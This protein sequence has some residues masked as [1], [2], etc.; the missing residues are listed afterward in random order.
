[1]AQL[2]TGTSHLEWPR[3][4]LQDLRF[5]S[6][7]LVRSPGF[8]LVAATVLALGIGAN[9]AIFCFVRAVVIAPLP[10]ANPDRLVAIWEANLAEGKDHERV[11]PPNFVDY[12]GRE[13]V[14][15]DAAAWWRFDANL[16][17]PAGEAL[18]VR[19]V[20]C[21]ANLFSILGVAPHLGHGFATDRLWSPDLAAVISYRL[22]TNRYRS[23]RDVIGSLITLNGNPY[24]VVGVMGPGFG[25]PSNDIDVWHRQSWDFSERTRYA[26]FM[27]AIGRLR[28]G[29]P[30]EQARNDLASLS[31]RLGR[32]YPAS[33]GDWQARLTLLQ[34]EIAGDY[35][36]AL[37][38]LMAAVGLL[39]LL[40]CANVASLLLARAHSR[41]A[42]MAIR[43]AVGASPARLLRLT[44]AEAFILSAVA[45]ALGLFLSSIVVRIL[46]VT[47]AVPIPRLDEVAFDGTVFAFASILA[48]IMV[49]LFG[50][51]LAFELHN[52]DLL[53]RLQDAGKRATGRFHRRT[54]IALV[55]LEVALATALLSGAGL[56][57]RSVSR[58]LAQEPG[59]DPHRVST[60]AVELPATLYPEWPRVSQLFTELLERLGANPAV[61]Q[62]GAT[63]FLPLTPAWIVGYKDPERP[64]DEEEQALR[65]QYV[66]VTP[67]YFET[68]RTPLITGRTFDRHDLA[69]SA[70]VVV[71]NEE[72][73]RRTWS[74][75]ESALGQT[76]RTGTRGFGPLGRALT[77]EQVF[78]VVGVVADLKNNGLDS[79]ADPTIYFGS[80]QFPYRTLHF[81]LT[82]EGT[83][84]QPVAVFRDELR[85][86]DP[87]LPLAEV[88]SM[89]EILGQASA[90]P[91][92][93][94]G[95]M[96][97]FAT[98]AVLLAA[99]GIYGLV[100]YTV[101]QRRYELAVRASVGATP[102]DLQ[103]QVFVENLL[104][105]VAGLVLGTL[106]ALALGRLLR[107]LLF[108]VSAADPAT[109]GAAASAIALVALLACYLPSRT[110]AKLDPIAT[111]RT[112]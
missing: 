41:G 68:I 83:T 71:V 16:T 112:G 38:M 35:G 42:E 56:L 84:E 100:S 37:S 62:V 86:L 111:L 26:H 101:S 22:W 66:T 80:A 1:M 106:L 72:L 15:E 12:R 3:K 103:Y 89:D 107:S 78:E 108:G 81:A 74:S 92:L 87:S 73:A 47:R 90:R 40:A 59:F 14:F 46:L 60:V 8:C 11:A 52:A 44:L 5:S 34:E 31:E 27:E 95:L 91:R 51:I 67:G 98:L 18:R 7:L 96:G 30:L 65:A 79:P 17:G 33:N 43:A 57:T 54:R 61:K 82:G 53:T 24:T 58:L 105:L 20:E 36:P 6:R 94:T 109:L 28:A 93:V 23:A 88:R 77:E 39:F 70:P 29:T 32:E 2:A 63:N 21:T 49:L 104:V 10:Y 4:V 97:V 19:T 45:T 55:I 9:L 48:S 76:L 25:F 69:D 13:E 99:I 85:R 50:T 64:S 102:G 75:A 110:A